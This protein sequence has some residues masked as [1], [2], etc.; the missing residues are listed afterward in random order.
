MLES[1]TIGT[2]QSGS[3]FVKA[4]VVSSIMVLC[5]GRD[6]K[7]V[8]Y[9]AYVCMLPTQAELFAQARRRGRLDLED[10]GTILEHGEGEY[11]PPEVKQRMHQQFG[12]RDD[13]EDTLLKIIQQMGGNP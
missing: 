5:R 9:W 2:K 13:Y 6:P 10:Y 11:P 7:N 4:E 3:G 12:F 1:N 8:A